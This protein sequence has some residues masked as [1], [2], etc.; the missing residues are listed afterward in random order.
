MKASAAALE[1]GIASPAPGALSPS[2]GNLFASA[3]MA[4]PQ[5]HALSDITK[6]CQGGAS[7]TAADEDSGPNPVN[8]A[9]SVRADSLM[10]AP[11]SFDTD[12][13]DVVCLHPA[14]VRPT[15]SICS[16][17]LSAGQIVSLLSLHVASSALWCC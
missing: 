9:A 13:V 15:A 7:E 11:A 1:G 16:R 4:S 3:D 17:D 2:A 12:G 5:Q 8:Q 14:Q 6:P 10:Q